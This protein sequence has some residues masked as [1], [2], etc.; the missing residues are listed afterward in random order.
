[1]PLIPNEYSKTQPVG[2][3][4]SSRYYIKKKVS[5]ESNKIFMS[6]KIRHTHVLMGFLPSC[7][8]AHMHCHLQFQGWVG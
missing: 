2:K 7:G 4:L 3:K 5:I 6:I 8:P 1:M